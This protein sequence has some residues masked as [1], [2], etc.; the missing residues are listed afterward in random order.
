M[1]LAFDKRSFRL[2]F[3]RGGRLGLAVASAVAELPLPAPSSLQPHGLASAEN[4][5][6]VFS[7]SNSDPWSLAQ[8]NDSR[9]VFARLLR[10]SE[11]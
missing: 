5:F 6:D 9:C 4:A 7:V 2:F 1:F 8:D 3:L 11:Q 10:A